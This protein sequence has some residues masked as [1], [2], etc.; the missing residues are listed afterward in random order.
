MSDVSKTNELIV[1]ENRHIKDGVL[2]AIPPGARSDREAIA[3]YRAT[4]DAIVA[5]LPYLER[6][7]VDRDALESATRVPEQGEASAAIER[8]RAVADQWNATPDYSPS[9]YDKGRVDQRHDMTAQLLAALDGA[10]EPEGT[11][12]FAACWRDDNGRL[13]SL[14]SS[15]VL[16]EHAEAD[17]KRWRGQEQREPNGQP[18]RVVLASKISYP[19]LPV[20]GESAP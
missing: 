12:W 17:V 6:H 5:A 4:R 13:N 9:E 10:P 19:W 11:R 14:E 7:F 16:R 8:V 2:A 15:T 3:R 20:E 18:D 1:Q